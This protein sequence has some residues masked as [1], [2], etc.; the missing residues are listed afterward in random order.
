[1]PLSLYRLPG[2]KM[3]DLQPRSRDGLRRLL[4]EAE[5]NWTEPQWLLQ[6]ATGW[7]QR[8]T[9]DK[10]VEELLDGIEQLRELQLRHAGLVDVA[11][12]PV[13]AVAA[14]AWC[15]A[16]ETMLEAEKKPQELAVLV[17]VFPARD[18][19]GHAAS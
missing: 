1:M 16:A 17:A 5:N 2:P 6:A 9:V 15:R 3:A 12:A 7:M 10:L 13:A 8:R 14:L 19:A 11:K 4:V 18:E